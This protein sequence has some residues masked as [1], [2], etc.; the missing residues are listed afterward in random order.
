MTPN[1]STARAICNLIDE[2]PFGS[3]D[4][5]LHELT[6]FNV[7]IHKKTLPK[8][9]KEMIVSALDTVLKLAATIP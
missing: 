1:S 2:S 7:K 4:W 5:L 6:K 8:E 9:I 3:S